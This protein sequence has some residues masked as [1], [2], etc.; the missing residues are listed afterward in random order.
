VPAEHRYCD[1]GSALQESPCEHAQRNGQ[2]P[3]TR[4][5]I[6]N[7]LSLSSLAFHHV[8][9]ACRDFDAEEKLFSMLGYQREGDDF[10]DP[11]QGV[12]GRFLVGAGPRLELLRN[13]EEP[14]VLSPWLKSRTKFYHLA[15]E[16]DDLAGSGLELAKLGAK[17]V[18]APVP[19]VAFGFRKISFHMLPNMAL[20]ELISRSLD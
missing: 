6:L 10:L 15:Y 8:G 9:V 19:A 17:Q 7:R 12:Y 5:D 11:I 3:R 20:I 1:R 4:G 14:G 16:T 18:V 2:R 13:Q